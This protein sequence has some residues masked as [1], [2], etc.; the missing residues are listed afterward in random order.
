MKTLNAAEAAELLLA[1]AERGGAGAALLVVG[2]TRADLLGRRLALTRGVAAGTEVHGSLDSPELDAAAAALL[3][4]VLDS[5]R[6][7]DGLRSLTVS[8]DT[9]EVYVEVRWPVQE[10]VIVGAGHIALPMAHIGSTLG[11]RVTVLDDR[12]DF[13]TLERFPTAHRVIR[14][15]FSDRYVRI[16]I[17][18]SAQNERLMTTVAT[19][20][21]AA[22]R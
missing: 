20:L 10:L 14:G 21:K 5:P 7:R 17:G 18:T 6:S 22:R 11:F 19:I 3:R 8:G 9:L 4:D 1:T 12:P 13:A 2:G 15:D 16:S